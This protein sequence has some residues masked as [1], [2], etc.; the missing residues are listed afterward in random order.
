METGRILLN[1]GL[2]DQRQIELSRDAQADGKRL[3][4]AAVRLGFITED[5]AL[6][7][8]LQ[9]GLQYVK[10]YGYAW[11]YAAKDFKKRAPAERPKVF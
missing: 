4:Q 11:D 10:A 3:D 9:M 8:S 5:A 2:L 6:K 1:K 7:R